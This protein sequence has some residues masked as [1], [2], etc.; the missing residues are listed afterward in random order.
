MVIMIT[1][2]APIFV[3][4]RLETGELRNDMEFFD[5]AFRTIDTPRISDVL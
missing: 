1:I 2:D 4:R 5:V 3:N